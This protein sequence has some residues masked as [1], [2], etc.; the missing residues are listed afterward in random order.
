MRNG[1]MILGVIVS[2][3]LFAMPAMA[4]MHN[5]NANQII[6]SATTSAAPRVEIFSGGASTTDLNL[7]G[8]RAF[9]Q[10]AREN[11]Q[12]V[13]QLHRNPRLINDPSYARRHPEFA[14]FLKTHPAVAEDL[15]ENPGNYLAG[16]R[17]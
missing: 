6:A 8:Y 7:N 12:I 4:Q 13:R 5:S 14:D 3:G 17:S 1:I 16:S 9:D 2:L 15:A 11:P 10:F